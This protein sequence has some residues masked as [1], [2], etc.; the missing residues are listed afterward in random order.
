MRLHAARRAATATRHDGW[1]LALATVALASSLFCPAL[2]DDRTA[3]PHTSS[4][5]EARAGRRELMQKFGQEVAAAVRARVHA[6]IDYPAEAL[7]NRWEGTVWLAILYPWG[8]GAEEISVHRSSGYPVL[9]SKALELE[10]GYAASKAEVLPL[11]ET[12]ADAGGGS[13]TRVVGMGIRHLAARR[14]PR[15]K[16]T[17]GMAAGPG[18]RSRDRAATRAL[19]RGASHAT[20]AVECPR[21][22]LNLQRTA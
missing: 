20:A 12:P 8:G 21:Q 2:A 19:T 4:E 11:D 3:T 7:A 18:W 5:T 22:D 6:G 9:D 15:E 1:R 14:R 17:A 13:R 16:V 10:P